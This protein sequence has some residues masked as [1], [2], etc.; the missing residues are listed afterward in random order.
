MG[1]SDRDQH[2][3]R[4]ERGSCHGEEVEV[5]VDQRVRPVREQEARQ[6]R[7]RPGVIAVD[8][9]QPSASGHDRAADH[10]EAE[11]ETHDSEVGE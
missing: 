11:D 6:G 3:Q 9:P 5:V 2:A 1:P 4:Q 8:E 7:S 10:G